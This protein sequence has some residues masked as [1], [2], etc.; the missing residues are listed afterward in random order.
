[1]PDSPRSSK[2]RAKGGESASAP[3]ADT[4]MAKFRALARDVLAVP[5]EQ[6]IE[7]EKRFADARKKIKRKRV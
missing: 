2:D 3:P 1:M 4:Q 5:Y 6:V 7:E